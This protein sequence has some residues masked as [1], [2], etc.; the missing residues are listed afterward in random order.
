MAQLHENDQA[1]ENETSRTGRWVPNTGVGG[2]GAPS[3][4]VLR[5]DVVN[6]GVVSVS[7]GNEKG[8]EQNIFFC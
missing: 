6:M 8:L 1:P 4:G 3:L 7:S 2:N 5:K